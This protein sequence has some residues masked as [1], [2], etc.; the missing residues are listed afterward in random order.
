[1]V[2]SEVVIGPVR[3]RGDANRLLVALSPVSRYDALTADHADAD[4]DA[5]AIEAGDSPEVGADGRGRYR[6]AQA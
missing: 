6:S 1:M 3:V 2:R 4:A 5:A